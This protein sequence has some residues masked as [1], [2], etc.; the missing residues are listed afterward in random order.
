MFQRENALRLLIEYTSIK[1]QM[2]KRKQI[3]LIKTLGHLSP[4][5]TQPTH[6]I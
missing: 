1:H 3:I 4:A 6:S 5:S 2:A